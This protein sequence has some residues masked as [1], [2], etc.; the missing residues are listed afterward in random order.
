MDDVVVDRKTSCCLDAYRPTFEYK[1]TST[2]LILFSTIILLNMLA[3]LREANF[4]I[5]SSNFLRKGYSTKE[6]PTSSIRKHLQVSR[7]QSC[8]SSILKS[9]KKKEEKVNYVAYI[10]ESRSLCPQIFQQ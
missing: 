5:V 8:P 6:G 4:P 9:V 2:V 1:L 10:G 7:K 3:I